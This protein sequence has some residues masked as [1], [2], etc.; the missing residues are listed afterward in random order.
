MYNK[1]A[2]SLLLAKITQ[3]QLPLNSP[4]L[5][6]SKTKQKAQTPTHRQTR[7]NKDVKV[8][9]RSPQRNPPKLKRTMNLSFREGLRG[10]TKLIHFQCSNAVNIFGTVSFKQTGA[11]A[12]RALA[13]GGRA[14]RRWTIKKLSPEGR[15]LPLLPRTS[16]IT[17]RTE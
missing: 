17:I 4:L 6:N 1:T 9:K 2:G 10:A 15:A 12:R 3:L 11:A 7:G 16:T 14:A 5:P 8:R 13:A